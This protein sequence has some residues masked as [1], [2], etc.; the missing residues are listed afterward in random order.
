M[1]EEVLGGYGPVFEVW[2]DGANGE[3]PNG[4]RQVYDWPLFI[5]TVRR[6]QPQAV[7][8][9]DAGPDIRWVGNER[10][11]APL[12]VW[13]TIDRARYEPGTPLSHELGEG[14]PYG[15]DWVPPE[16]D[17]SIRP[18]WFYRASEDRRVKSAS[19]LFALYEQSV[20]RNCTLLLNVPPDRR[21]LIADP[22]LA[23]LSGMRERLD[24]VYGRDL[25]AGATVA[26]AGS[27]DHAAAA[28]GR[29][30]SIG[31]SSRRTSATASTSPASRSR[32]RRKAAWRRMATGSTVGY[33]RILPVAVDDRGRRARHRPRRARHAS[34]QPR[35]A[36]PRRVTRAPRRGARVACPASVCSRDALPRREER[37]QPPQH[38]LVRPRAVLADLERLGH[39]HLVAG[40]RAVPLDQGLAHLG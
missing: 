12:T 17:V 11:E 35:F 20:G 23:A 27:H 38:R 30:R 7:M 28:G 33:K 13:S 37:E 36:P 15:A 1:L 6:L 25:A 26:T 29:R 39:L 2:F 22:D 21:G 31:S 16:C 4:K 19:R 18:G 5:A 10:G 8:F 14:T 40:I 32:R 24:R 9:S 34:H 3:G